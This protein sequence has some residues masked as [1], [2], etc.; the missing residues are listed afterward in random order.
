MVGVLS[1]SHEK[2]SP[3]PLLVD[4]LDNLAGWQLWQVFL[5]HRASCCTVLRVGQVSPL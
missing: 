2:I 5:N 4:N 3:T 1:N